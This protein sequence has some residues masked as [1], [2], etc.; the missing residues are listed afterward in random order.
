MEDSPKGPR[1]KGNSFEGC[2]EKISL[3]SRGN[4]LVSRIN[5]NCLVCHEREEE[6]I[7]KELHTIR[8]FLVG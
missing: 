1:H 7:P 6:N 2:E 8:Y 5:I 3:W 4:S